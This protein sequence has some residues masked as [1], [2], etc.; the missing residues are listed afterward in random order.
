MVWKCVIVLYVLNKGRSALRGAPGVGL[1]YFLLA[2]AVVLLIGTG[3]VEVYR[4]LEQIKR[5]RQAVAS[6]VDD[7]T[8]RVGS[9]P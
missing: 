2:L 7:N 5:A 6:A 1:G 9:D 4:R 8:C 3:L